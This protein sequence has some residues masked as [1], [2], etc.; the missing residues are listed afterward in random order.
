MSCGAGRSRRL[1]THGCS[2]WRFGSVR[3]Y[4]AWRLGR[5]FCRN[6]CS[7]NAAES[8]VGHQR[9]TLLLLLLE[10]VV[11]G[12]GWVEQRSSHYLTEY[13]SQRITDE[14]MYKSGYRGEVKNVNICAEGTHYSTCSFMPKSQFTP[15]TESPHQNDWRAHAVTKVEVDSNPSEGLCCRSGSPSHT[16]G[17]Y[18]YLRYAV[19]M[20]PLSL[21]TS[22]AIA[23]A[24][25][26]QG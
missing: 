4:G 3:I 13:H 6:Y 10:V 25:V 15:K 20:S 11:S 24:M 23:R 7:G 22:G 14:S 21:V 8:C 26:G 12:M 9:R 2:S 16:S 17:K 1:S 5:T 18:I 19:R